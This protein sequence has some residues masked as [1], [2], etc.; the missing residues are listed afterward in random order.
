MSSNVNGKFRFLAKNTFYLP[1]S[2]SSKPYLSNTYVKKLYVGRGCG[3][4]FTFHVMAFFLAQEGK[5]RI[6]FFSVRKK[7]GKIRLSLEHNS[8]RSQKQNI[9]IPA[10]FNFNRLC[11]Y[12]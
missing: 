2:F 7:V 3:P 5:E 1:G 12:R 6:L 11:S 10:D 9:F 8:N 4:F